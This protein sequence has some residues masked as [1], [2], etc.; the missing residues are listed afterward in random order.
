VY[1]SSDA[2]QKDFITLQNQNTL[3]M[4]YHKEGTCID[5]CLVRELGDFL[6]ES[7]IQVPTPFAQLNP[8]PRSSH[9][10]D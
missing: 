6:M 1:R 7:D 10:H 3:Q 2:Y 9:T 5:R 4:T 8:E